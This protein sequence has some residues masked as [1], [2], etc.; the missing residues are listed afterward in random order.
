MRYGSASTS[1]PRRPTRKCQDQVMPSTHSWLNRYRAGDRDAVWHELRQAGSQVRTPEL[2]DDAQ[3]VC[4]EMARRARQNVDV[5]VERLS[6]QG[7]VV[8]TNDH[9]QTPVTPHHA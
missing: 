1:K 7:Y 2:I 4:G 3:A 6:E 8:H 9:A 5:I